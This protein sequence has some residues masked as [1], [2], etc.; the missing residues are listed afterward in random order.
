M[1]L[2]LDV[3]NT[4]IVLGVYGS[5]KLL[6]HWRMSTKREWTPDE[7]GILLKQL[8]ADKELPVGEVKDAIVSSVVPPLNTT[9][10]KAFNTYFGFVPMFVGPGIKTG[11]PI[12]YENS[13]DV[14]ADRIVNAIAAQEQYGL[15]LILVDFGTAITFC[16]ISLKGEYL[17]GVIVPGIHIALEALFS[18]A[19]KLPRVELAAPAQVIGRNTTHSMQS[20][21]LYGYSGLVDS[22]VERMNK[23]MEG[24]PRVIATGGGAE[25][26]VEECRSI[27][28]VDQF[29]TLTGL[30]LIYRRNSEE[31]PV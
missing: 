18:K 28:S 6:A 13:R 26:I 2:V 7:F 29:L 15:P 10:S 3:G 27:Q 9:I 1:L 30:Q 31:Q 12:K 11:M 5:E 16:A 23:E 4:N 19:A 20:G 8:L 25:A 14:G 22:I 21:I 24:T 17:G